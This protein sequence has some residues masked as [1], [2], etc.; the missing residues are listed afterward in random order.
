MNV[1]LDDLKS[2]RR[3][4]GKSQ[5]EL[6]ELLAVSTRAVQSYEQG[7][8]D[9][10]L[11]VQKAAAMLLFLSWRKTRTWVAPCWEIKKCSEEKRDCCPAYE[12]RAGEFCWM[13][14]GTQCGQAHHRT[15]ETK[16]ELCQECPVTREWLSARTES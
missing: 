14:N 2:I 5:S 16:I 9:T 12:M 15:W 11:H 13:V 4:L 10:P 7:W 1:Q 6:A 3:A 8:R